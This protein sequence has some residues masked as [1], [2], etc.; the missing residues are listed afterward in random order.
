[1][2]E[3]L[4]EILDKFGYIGVTLLIALENIFPPIPSEVILTFGGFM[5]ASTSMSVASVIIFATLGS[6]LGALLLYALGYLLGSERLKPLLDQYGS[7]IHLSYE[8]VQKALKWYSRYEGKTVFFC[9]MVPLIRS[10]ISIPAGMA[11]MSI[12]AFILLTTLGS[13]IWNSVLVFAGAMLGEH[14]A[15]ILTIMDTYSWITYGLLFVGLLV[16]IIRWI[17]KKD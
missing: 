17:R 15:D 11:K 1:M 4:I 10:L 13:L 5:T 12:S 7:I 9:R 6:L 14:W 2:A 16:V 3:T 8:D